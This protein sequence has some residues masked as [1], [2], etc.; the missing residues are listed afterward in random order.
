MQK[1]IVQEINFYGRVFLLSLKQTERIIREPEREN[2]N[3]GENV[4]KQR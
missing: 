4:E 2:E 1:G 3:F